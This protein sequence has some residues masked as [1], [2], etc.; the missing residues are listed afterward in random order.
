MAAELTFQ[1]ISALI[2]LQEA[3][4]ICHRDLHPGNLMV[5]KEKDDEEEEVYVMKLID[6]NVAR[7]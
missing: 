2:H 4:F 7:V 3:N 1:T 6:F 5:V